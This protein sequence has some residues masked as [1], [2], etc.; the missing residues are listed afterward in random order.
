M[1]VSIRGLQAAS[2]VVA[3]SA[4]EAQ[5]EPPVLVGESTGSGAINAS[6][7]AGR[8]WFPAGGY[9]V[10][11]ET[12]AVEISLVADGDTCPVPSDTPRTVVSASFDGGRSWRPHHFV[13]KSSAPHWHGIPP[14]PSFC[15]ATGVTVSTP[16]AGLLCP[17]D[18]A[19][20]AYLDHNGTGVLKLSATIWSV[21]SSNSRTGSATPQLV[22]RPVSQPIVLRCPPGAKTLPGGWGPGPVRPFGLTPSRQPLPF[23]RVA[24]CSTPPPAGSK[25]SADS[26]QVIMRSVDG[27]WSWETISTIPAWRDLYM[28]GK[29]PRA[30]EIALGV[31]DGTGLLV[32]NRVTTSAVGA[33]HHYVNYTMCW[34]GNMGKTWAVWGPEHNVSRAMAGQWSVMPKILQL[35]SGEVMLAGGR[36]GIFIWRGGRAE[37]T[38]WRAVNVAAEHNRGLTGSSSNRH[39]EWSYDPALVSL[40]PASATNQTKCCPHPNCTANGAWCQSTAYS[41]IAPIGS[42]GAKADEEAEFVI[43][44]DRLANGW[45]G[46]PGQWG[47]LDRVFSMRFRLASD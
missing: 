18:P 2:L 28:F 34:S 4:L 30:D 37:G 11:S 31:V 16:S 24:T 21:S 46:P 10:D 42:H 14:G 15:G 27:G 3:A 44:Y 32:V 35:P 39:P 20:P 22:P 41:S 9:A 1:A 26:T 19:T 25:K 8:F 7:G 43:I 5:F 36:P 12:L 40:T 45:G 29:Y 23:Y 13:G 38:Q 47:E 17:G 6:C 33:Q